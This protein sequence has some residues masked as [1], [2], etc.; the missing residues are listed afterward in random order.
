MNNLTTVNE[1]LDY[2]VKVQSLW[3]YLEAV[4]VGGD[5]GRQLPQEAR[6]FLSVDKSWVKIID[7]ARETPSVVVCCTSDATL[8][9]LLPRMLE[10]LEICQR[11]LSGYLE[12]KRLLFPR[13]F[14][15]SDP[16]LLE[17]LGQAST[18]EAVQPHLLTIFDSIHHLQF[19]KES[20]WVSAAYSVS[21][22]ELAVGL[23]GENAFPLLSI[24][25]VECSLC[26][27]SALSKAEM[28]KA[29][30]ASTHTNKSDR[31]TIPSIALL[32]VAF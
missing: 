21:N 12:S 11:S 2:W 18:P 5:I 25:D 6:R 20:S 13:F 32:Y 29:N 27:V 4:F 3:V 9:E 16:V 14:F 15:V 24:I 10:Q 22:E 19:D 8:L 31:Q 7:R 26:L 28:T 30:R 17:I 23:F 1:V